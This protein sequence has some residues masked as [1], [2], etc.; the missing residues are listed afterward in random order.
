MLLW[1]T[2]ENAQKQNMV[3]RRAIRELSLI[4]SWF[5]TNQIITKLNPSWS[6]ENQIIQSIYTETQEL[7]SPPEMGEIVNHLM[8]NCL[9]WT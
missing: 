1:V 9:R 7:N 8:L 6:F 4:E 2:I 3:I 5:A